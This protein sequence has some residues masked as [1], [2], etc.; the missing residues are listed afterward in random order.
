[1]PKLNNITGNVLSDISPKRFFEAI[2]QVTPSKIRIEADEVSY[3]LH[4][5]IRFNIEKDIFAG[6]LSIEPA[7]NMEPELSR[8]SRR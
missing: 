3:G 2:N 8:L 1:M 6:K 4:V 5:I 7:R